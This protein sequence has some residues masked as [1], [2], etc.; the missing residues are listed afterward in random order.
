MSEDHHDGHGEEAVDLAGDGGEFAPGVVGALQ[1]DGD[2]DVGFEQATLDGVVGEETGFAA[3][4]LVGELEEEVGGFPIRDEG[5]GLVERVA[6]GEVGEEVLRLG[7]CADEELVALV[8]Q[9]GEKLA[10]GVLEREGLE[11]GEGGFHECLFKALQAAG[12]KQ[13][14]H[15]GDGNAIERG[16]P[17]GLG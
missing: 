9:L 7:A 8:A 11:I 6:G 14:A 12:G 5:L 1:L 4:F 16:E 13:G 2:E 17:L 10:G 3:E 15:L